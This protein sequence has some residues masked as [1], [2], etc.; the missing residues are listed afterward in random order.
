[1]TAETLTAAQ[2]AA[3]KP[4]P[5][6]PGAGLV[7]AVYGEYAIAANVEDGDIFEMCR[8]PAGALVVG[9]EFWTTDM[10]TGTGV[11]DMDVGWAANGAETASAAG[12][13]NCGAMNGTAVTNIHA[14]GNYRP[15][16]MA[17]GPIKFTAETMVQV[18]ANVAANTFAAG[19]IYVVVYYLVP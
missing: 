4:V 7:H 11:L 15:F 9:G 16:V 5:H 19:T 8:L 3:G 2:A 14:G 13:V 17:A 12:F 18:E 6:F 10:D 1:M